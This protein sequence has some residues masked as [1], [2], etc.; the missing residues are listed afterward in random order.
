[1]TDPSSREPPAAPDVTEGQW[2]ERA[3]EYDAETDTYRA[4]FDSATGSASTAVISTVAAVSGTPPME[5]PP[6]H[7]ACE[8]DA[9]EALVEPTTHEQSRTDVHVSFLYD[10]Y[11]VT[12]HSY[13][14]VAVQPPQADSDSSTR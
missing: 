1:M 2:T 10:G 11:T 8:T 4:S 7:T 13:G 6:L 9:L 3:V 14:I 5:L 12:V